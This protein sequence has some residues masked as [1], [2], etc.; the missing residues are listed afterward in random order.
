MSNINNVHG[1]GGEF[2]GEAMCVV[3]TQYEARSAESWEDVNYNVDLMC[4]WI[5]RAV[6]GYPNCDMVVTCECGFQGFGKNWKKLL[7]NIDGPEIK[8]VRDKC[9]D[10]GIWGVFCPVLDEVDGKYACNCAILV[11]DKGEIVHNYVK[12]NP[13]TPTEAT[14]PGWE[15][16]VSEGPKGSK[17][18]TIVCYDG[19]FPEMWREA[20]LKGANVIIRPA[21][22]MPPVEDAWDFTNRTAAYCN[23]CYVIST[24]AIGVDGAYTYFGKSIAVGP[25]G[26]VITQAPPMVPW[27]TKVDIFP[28]LVDFLREKC[29]VGNMLY[30]LKHRGAAHPQTFGEGLDMTASSIATPDK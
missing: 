25:D 26:R 11:N 12:W 14:Y 30:S 20:A 28:S 2:K 16:P 8:R 10:Y 22:A 23:T 15:L 19:D 6:T 24:N 21:H 29:P 7:L 18:A 17:I 9:R 4:D 5:D 3:M 13:W 27:M 1:L